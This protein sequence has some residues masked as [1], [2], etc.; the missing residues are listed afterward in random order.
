[1]P[2]QLSISIIGAG[3]VGQ[4]LGKLWCDRGHTIEAVVC[5]QIASGRQAVRFIGVGTPNPQRL[6]SSSLFLLS[7][8]DD[9]LQNSV[10][11]L[12]RLFTDL[13]G[14]VV[15]HTS[16][17][18]NSSILEPLGKIGAFVGSMHPLLSISEPKLA[19]DQ[20]AG[21]FFCVEGEKLATAT[22]N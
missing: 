17:S 22:A 4:T 16:G 21:G 19:I 20:V 8:P 18:L 11:Y 6:P 2:K 10:G 1:M 14:S 12:Q 9:E 5:R 15:L 13:K 3:R 7:V